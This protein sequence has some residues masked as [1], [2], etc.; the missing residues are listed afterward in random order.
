M[1][2]LRSCLALLL[3]LPAACGSSGRDGDL[4]AG[5]APGSVDEHRY[6]LPAAQVWAA[7]QTAVEEDGAV[8]ELRRPASDGGEIVVRR[9]EGSRVQATVTAVEPHA[10]RVAVA[11]SPANGTLGAMI[12]ARIGE[13]LSLLKA[14]A[15]L[16]GETSVETVYPR[17]LEA[18]VAA[19]ERTCRTLD[20]EIVRRMTLGAHARVEAR[21][22]SSRAI[23]FSFR[24]IGDGS[25]ETAVMFTA[26]S[27]PQD[28][29]EQVRREF[30]RHLF[31][32][33]E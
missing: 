19:A 8:V 28:R 29:L 18:S 32:A 27:A 22:R 31:P 17:S 25:R 5:A 23:R 6:E 21:D 30:E 12:Q 33:R 4:E 2:T 7:A 10:T 9:S 1:R 15:D 13:R 24:R 3:A 11:V 26:E 20:M 16:F 14:Q